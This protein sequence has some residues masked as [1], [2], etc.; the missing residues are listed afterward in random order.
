MISIECK[1][2][3]EKY[4]KSLE[5]FW[6]RLLFQVVSKVVGISKK[7]S[8]CFKCALIVC[9]FGVSK[10]SSLGTFFTQ[11]FYLEELIKFISL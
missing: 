6:F 3:F 1:N 8:K 4:K 9:P 11:K 2:F 10:H 7:L 5:S